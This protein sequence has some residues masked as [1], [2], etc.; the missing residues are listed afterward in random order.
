MFPLPVRVGDVY[1]MEFEHE[2][3]NL[4]MI[5]GRCLRCQL[6]R[7]DAFEAGFKFFAALDLSAVV[8]KKTDQVLI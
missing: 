7:E 5:F 2:S 8:E 3:L 6:V 4:P 1:R